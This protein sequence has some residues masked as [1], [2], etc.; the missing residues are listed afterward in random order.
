MEDDLIASLT[1]QVKEEVI[2]NYV[3]ERR[4]VDLQI[5]DIDEQAREARLRAEVTGW[6]LTRLSHLMLENDMRQKLAELLKVPDPSF[7]A[8]YLRRKLPRTLP[9]L[10]VGGLTQKTRFRKLVL[11]AYGRF[12]LWMQK[13]CAAYDQLAGNVRAV[14]VNIDVFQKNFDVL[15][16]LAFLRSLDM[17]AI[18]M[19]KVLGQNFTSLELASLDQKLYLKP[20]SFEK[21]DVPAP[22]TLPGKEAM[23]SAISA[24]AVDVYERYQVRARNCML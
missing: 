6:R 9:I 10:R 1:R 16:I 11:E 15:A 24:L 4:L 13:Y 23:A 7:W 2:E 8:A 18:E 3:R 17:Q 14:N 12:H 22:L 5:E 21:L 20:V 19:K